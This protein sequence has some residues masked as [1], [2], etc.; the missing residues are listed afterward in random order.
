MIKNCF[1]LLVIILLSPLTIVAKTSITDE[2]PYSSFCLEAARNSNTFID[3]KQSP[4]FREVLEHVTF[5]QG[6]EYLRSTLKQTAHYES[7]MNQF[8]QNDRLGKPQVYHY[9]EYGLLSPT[10]LRY[11]KVASDLQRQFGSLD[12][13]RIIEIGGGYGGQCLILSK[14]FNWKS[15]TMVELEGPKELC[16]KYLDMNNVKNV[17]YLHP[18]EVSGNEEYDLVISNFTLSECFAPVQEDYFNNILLKSK[19]GYITNN[20]WRDLQ[21]A[22]KIFS[23]EAWIKKFAE[24]NMAVTEVP[25]EPRTNPDNYVLIW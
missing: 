21:Q 9:G 7:L 2:S 6:I 23:K 15:Y 16:R 20:T 13:M 4:V 14:L 8:Q 1:K 5:E 3:F 24:K 12:N 25:E 11:I 22:N 19:H 18:H 17:T 10:T